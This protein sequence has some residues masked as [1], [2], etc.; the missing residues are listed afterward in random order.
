MI[1]LTNIS[2]VRHAV[3]GVGKDG[4]RPRYVPVRGLADDPEV[5]VHVVRPDRDLRALAPLDDDKVVLI[6][7]TPLPQDAPRLRVALAFPRGR[8]R[9]KHAPNAPWLAG[10]ELDLRKKTRNILFPHF[11]SFAFVV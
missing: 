1:Q 4:L 8:E 10:H 11:I 2:P 9:P 6:E 3:V 5:A 7:A